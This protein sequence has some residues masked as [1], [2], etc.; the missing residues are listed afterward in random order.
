MGDKHNTGVNNDSHILMETGS[1]TWLGSP[2]K[3]VT[4]TSFFSLSRYPN[5]YD[6]I[7]TN[8]QQKKDQKKRR[9]EV[10]CCDYIAAPSGHGT[11]EHSH[12]GWALIQGSS[13]SFTLKFPY[14]AI[15]DCL[16]RLSYCSMQT[17]DGKCKQCMHDFKDG[18]SCCISMD[19][20]AWSKPEFRKF[21]IFLLYPI[22]WPPTFFLFFSALPFCR[23]PIDHHH[24]IPKP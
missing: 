2:V 12:Q 15:R 7:K 8:K 9:C 1:W 22:I 19:T 17:T 13:S 10:T 24:E 5:N 14:R 11:D 23:L 21:Y 16:P 3:A 20:T 4:H 18:Y 6:V